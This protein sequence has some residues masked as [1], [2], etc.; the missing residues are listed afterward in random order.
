MIVVNESITFNVIVE[1][2]R[3]HSYT[4]QWYKTSSDSLPSA[5]TGQYTPNLIIKSVTPSD[6]GLYYCEVTNQWGNSIAS[7]SELLK[8]LCKFT[9]YTISIA[10]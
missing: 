3:D 10:S 4:Y 2:L 7:N 8:V 9:V 1:G 6:G 5:S